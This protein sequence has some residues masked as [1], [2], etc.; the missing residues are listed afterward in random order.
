MVEPFDNSITPPS[1]N[2]LL[3]TG[4][5]IIID[6]GT[7]DGVFVFE[8]ARQNPKKFYI[9][10]DANARPL[11]KISEKI[12]RK[13]AKGGLPNVLFLQAA[14]ED[15]P[16]ELDGAADEV[17]IHFP[18]G[19]LL[20]AVATGNESVLR[21]LRRICAADALL[22]ILIGC[23]PVRDVGELERLG[24]PSFSLDYIDSLLAPR[25]AKGGFSIIE[26]GALPQSEWA[27][28]QTSWARRLKG[29][30]GRSLTYMIG[31]AM[32]KDHLQEP[33]ANS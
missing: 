19:S 14:V 33:S 13:P 18:W 9:G 30:A 25:Y 31:R 8:C 11:E 29:R 21:N 2:S 15:L 28:V 1:R 26:R 32:S 16:S 24:I 23:D 5:G 12:H 22:E 7:G 20:G 6:I 4:E 27:S 17:H 3:P 10:I